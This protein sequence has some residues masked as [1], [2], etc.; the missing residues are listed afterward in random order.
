MKS[1]PHPTV[2][3]LLYSSGIRNFDT[4]SPG[5]IQLI[6]ERFPDA[7]CY[8][9]HA[10]KSRQ[11]IALA[12]ETFRV[13]HFVVDHPGEL[14]KLKQVAGKADIV[15]MVRVATRGGDAKFDLSAKFGATPEVAAEL[16]DSAHDYGFETGLCFHVGSQCSSTSAFDH[17]FSEIRKVLSQTR[18]PISL[19]DVGGGFPARYEGAVAPPFEAFLDAIRRGAGSFGGNGVELMC[20]PGRALVAEGMSLLTRVRLRKENHIYINDGVYGSLLLMTIGLR[21][22]LRLV[23]PDGAVGPHD[24]EYVVYG[25]TCD[26]LDELPQRFRLPPDV[27]EGD[28]IE[29][30]CMGAYTVSLR[31][32]FNGFYTDKLVTVD[33]PFRTLVNPRRSPAA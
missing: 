13:R 3:D 24:T 12:L 15:V 26:G 16:L 28:W 25:P 6:G 9:M 22:P 23:R 32:T 30:G 8:F 27:R 31:T 19:M 10:V 1:N 21:L 33:K 7:S 17:A 4:A 18:A 11:A 5:E 29:I 2:L 14:D 20:E